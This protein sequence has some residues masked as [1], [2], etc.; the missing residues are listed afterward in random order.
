MKKS[1]IV[2]IGLLA[3]SLASCHNRKKSNHRAMNDWQDQQNNSFVS[4]DGG[5]N[6]NGVNN[7]IPFLYYYMIMRNGNGYSYGPAASYRTRNTFVNSSG[8]KS[9][10]TK[11]SSGRSFG[12]SR[13]ISRGG[14]GSSSHS[15]SS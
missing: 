10:S 8:G 1:K 2:A 15:V 6:Y 4:T 3:V 13:G 14:F 9:Y 12:S 7:N 11:S 5:N